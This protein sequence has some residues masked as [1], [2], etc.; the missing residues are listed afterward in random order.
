RRAAP[1]EKRPFLRLQTGESAAETAARVEALLGR[2][3]DRSA[4]VG[5]VGLGYVG[6]PFAVEKAKVGYRVVGIDQNLERA[7]KINAG[8][9]YIPDV[10]DE[11][12]RALV[13]GGKLQACTDFS[14]VPEMDVIVIAVPTPLTSNL[15]PDLRFVEGV[16]RELAGYIRPGQLISLES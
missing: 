1:W 9:N 16:T 8:E 7:R 14:R 3:H 11:E 6:L 5:I 15:T 12:L 10:R 13:Q 2:I 4:I